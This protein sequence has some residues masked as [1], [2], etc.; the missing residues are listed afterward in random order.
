M[1]TPLLPTGFHFSNFIQV[2]PEA[3]MTPSI[4]LVSQIGN[5]GAHYFNDCVMLTYSSCE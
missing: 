5:L 3:Y 2:P 1:Y 4:A